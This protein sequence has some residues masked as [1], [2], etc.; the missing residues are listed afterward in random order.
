MNIAPAGSRMY[1]L[2]IA[3]STCSMILVMT[4]FFASHQS[5]DNVI[6][7]MRITRNVRHPAVCL[8]RMPNIG[9]WRC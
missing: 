2:T 1:C 5:S 3:L 9:C 8:S 4:V 6:V 7:V